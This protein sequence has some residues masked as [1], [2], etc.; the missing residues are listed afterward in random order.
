MSFQDNSKHKK[1]SISISP[2]KTKETVNVFMS[3]VAIVAVLLSGCGKKTEEDYNDSSY[4]NR[5]RVVSLAVDKSFNAPDYSLEEEVYIPSMFNVVYDDD[6]VVDGDYY[7][8]GDLEHI[9]RA[10]II[11]KDETDYDFLNYMPNLTEL[12]IIDLSTEYK[13]SNID[14]SRLSKNL[15]INNMSINQGYFDEERY[16]FL[17]GISSIDSLT[18]SPG[19]IVNPYFLQELKLVKNLSLSIDYYTNFKY[20]DLTHL[21]SLNLKGLPYD[22][23]LYI[24]NEDIEELEKAGVDLTISDIDKVKSINSRIHSIYQSLN[25]SPNTSDEEKLQSILIYVLENLEYD[26]QVR[27]SINNGTDSEDQLQKFYSEG[28]M[29]AAFENDTQICGNYAALTYALCREA[30]LDVYNLRSVNHA[31][32]AVK[33]GE[34]YYFVDS[35]W[36]D[37]CPL[38]VAEQTQDENTISIEYRA[39]PAEEV[40]KSGDKE[41]I[42]SLKWYMEDP[43]NYPETERSESHVVEDIP[44]GLELKPIPLVESTEESIKDI[45][46][47]G[48]KKFVIDIKGNKYVIGGAALVGILSGMGIGICIHQRK[49][50]EQRRAA[51]ARMEREREKASYESSY[52]SRA[53]GSS[54]TYTPPYLAPSRKSEMDSRFKKGSSRK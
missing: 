39:V 20:I 47:V 14:P 44:W 21:E 8:Y 45:E 46:S 9:Q 19:V 12:S 24:S 53:F 5:P 10:T 41:N 13:F 34:Y 22:I 31:W 18:I 16:P 50:E 28:E 48:D 27:E 17:K 49:L 42:S 15:V 38:Y 25:I 7:T 51:K 40:L 37:D 32:N 33:V 52:N 11:V 29:T 36:L 3:G 35:S 26:E 54:S 6:R 43:T 4:E 30:G 23:A 2:R 1:I